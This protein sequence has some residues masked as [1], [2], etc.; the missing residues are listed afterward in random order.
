VPYVLDT[1]VVREFYVAAPNEKVIGWLKRQEPENLFITTLNVAEIRYGVERL[2]EGKKRTGL[3]SWLDDLLLP[4]FNGRILAFELQS[5]KV[6][7]A[8]MAKDKKDGR[9]RPYM[10]SLLAAVAL[11]HSMHLVT[12][13]IKDFSGLGVE[14]VNPFDDHG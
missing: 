4:N 2:P 7:G 10:D 13:N 1:N 5:A 6:W 9:P 11:A 3:E 14:L 8:I 12:R